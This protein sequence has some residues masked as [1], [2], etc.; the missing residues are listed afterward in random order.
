MV[1]VSMTTVSLSRD[2]V[3]CLNSLKGYPRETYE[4]VVK[5]LVKEARQK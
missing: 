5:R 2:T 1:F 3:T 4:D